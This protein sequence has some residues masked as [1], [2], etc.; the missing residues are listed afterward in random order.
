MASPETQ[1][2]QKR[3]EKLAEELKA[4]HE[5]DKQLAGEVRRLVESIL[6]ASAA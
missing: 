2:L 5:R 6:R 1:E 3:V 4:A